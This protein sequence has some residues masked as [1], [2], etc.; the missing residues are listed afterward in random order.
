[1]DVKGAE[2]EIGDFVMWWWHDMRKKVGKV[3]CRNKITYP[4]C[5]PS[6]SESFIVSKQ[7]STR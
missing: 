1:M 3:K 5:V 6:M 4:F 2:R 7:L